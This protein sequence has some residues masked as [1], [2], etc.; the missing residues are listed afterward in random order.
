MVQEAAVPAG[1]GLGIRAPVLRALQ[2]PGG[3]QEGVFQGQAMALVVKNAPASA[4]DTGGM[5]S[6]PAPGRCSEG[7]LGNPV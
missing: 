6:I 1:A 5:G 3:S 2:P 7:E 4:G